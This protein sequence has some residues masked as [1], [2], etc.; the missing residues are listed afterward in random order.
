MGIVLQELPRSLLKSRGLQKLRRTPTAIDAFT[1]SGLTDLRPCVVHP[2]FVFS[3][4]F[5]PPNEGMKQPKLSRSPSSLPNLNFLPPSLSDSHPHY[6]LPRSPVSNDERREKTL[7][8]ARH[9]GTRTHATTQ[10]T[11]SIPLSPPYCSS[12]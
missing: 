8:P 7:P 9:T 5:L 11:L 3:C 1:V 10:N 4:H 12:D 6:P 2:A